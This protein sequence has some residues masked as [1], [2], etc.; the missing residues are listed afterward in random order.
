MTI[1]ARTVHLDDRRRRFLR[2]AA[3]STASPGSASFTEVRFDG[4][5]AVGYDGA[6]L[7]AARTGTEA[8][9]GLLAGGR[10][11]GRALRSRGPS[12]AVLTAGTDAV[13]VTVGGR[14]ERARYG[15]GTAPYPWRE[16]VTTAPSGTV[17][18]PAAELACA[19]RRAADDGGLVF[20]TPRRLSVLVYG[21]SSRHPVAEV[22]AQVD[23]DPPPTA[24]FP[25]LFLAHLAAVA[26]HRAVALAFGGPL[27]PVR[28]STDGVDA[29]VMPSRFLRPAA[30]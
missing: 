6:R 12:P 28:T 22:E 15:S 17:R 7:V 18:L 11:L 23:G 21:E 30:A 16:L 14:T 19:C 24:F 4:G 5:H 26:D 29:V 20:L 8:F 13:H 1:V 3:D 25:D 27:D 2:A 10:A 9:D